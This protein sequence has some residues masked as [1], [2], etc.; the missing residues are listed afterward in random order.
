MLAYIA[1]KA[2]F[3]E[4]APVIEDKVQQ[5]VR[6]RLGI[7][8]GP[9]E[10]ASWR[11]S[12][13]NAMFHVMNSPLIPSD[14]AVAI[15][16]QINK[17]KKRIDFIV[18]GKGKDDQENIVIIELKQ[19]TNVN[20]SDLPEHVITF[21]GKRDREMP[22][23]SYQARSYAS[24]LEMYNQYVY[25]KPVNVSSCVYLHN[26]IDESVVNDSRYEEALRNTPIFLHGEKDALVNLI[27]TNIKYG[28]GIEILR[29]VDGSPIRPSIQLADAVA[30][31]LEGKEAFVLIDDQKTVLESILYAA[32]KSAE[33]PKQV[34]IINGGPGTGKSVVAINALSR[35]IGTRANAR[36][37]TPN[38]AP[39]A[40]FEV[41]LKD[42]FKMGQ[43]REMFSGSGSF[44]GLGENDF[45]VLI[46]DEAHRLKLR[47]QYSKGGDN[48]I[49]EII[50]A[51]RTS[52]FFIDESQ[53]VT[54]KDIGEVAEIKKFAKA[55]NAEV[56][57]LN[58]TSQFRCNGSEGYID[59]LDEALLIR[60]VD[61]TYFGTDDYDFQVFD[62]ALDLY[63]VIR[64]KNKSNNKSRML[65]GYCWDWISKKK[66]ELFDFSKEEFGFDAKWNLESRGSAWIIDANSVD[67][68]GCIHTAQGLELDYVGV[69]IGP[70]FE[71]VDG[72]L[73]SNPAGRAKTDVSLN[74]FKKESL[75][76]PQLAHEK[77]DQIIRNTY[78][79]LMTRGM[80]GCY[81]YC[82]DS[83]VAE[84]FK[85]RL[86]QRK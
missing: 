46:V 77:A 44:T 37:V 7:G 80:K 59:W 13:G 62:N 51:A 33:S 70:D 16:Y 67:D 5:A 71:I 34:L 58:L 29:S 27:S 2:K 28:G 45:D 57:E 14:A 39:R 10:L 22:H 41:R 79:T 76:D 32:A 18:A 83:M 30:K 74:G 26:C 19:W 8:V 6:S 84:Y 35:L 69:I 78:R 50:H 64:D 11:N 43:I 4:D 40:V 36:Y 1:T 85:N 63:K 52:V 21:V 17:H 68:I 53:K 31:M 75:E 42:S 54:W 72:Q 23:P 82:T 15:E 20:F 73:T 47:T 25:E 24:L 55:M 61:S 60:D 3:L 48:Q 65:A 66:I 86:E 56:T 38:A 81:I 12:L 49:R 9:N